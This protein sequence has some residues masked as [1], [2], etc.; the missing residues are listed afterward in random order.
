MR[1]SD[2]SSDVCSS[3]LSPNGTSAKIQCSLRGPLVLDERI[4]SI[5]QG[6]FTQLKAGWGRLRKQKAKVRAGAKICLA[7][8]GG[9]HVRQLL[10]LEPAWRGHDAFF[11]TEDKALGESLAEHYRRSEE[12]TSETQSIMTHSYAAFILKKTQ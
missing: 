9:G 10:D 5:D 11:V 1:I 2:W 6:G 4:H 8:S 12:Q 7:G 3:D